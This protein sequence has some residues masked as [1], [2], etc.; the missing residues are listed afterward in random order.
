[1]PY[2][3]KTDKDRKLWI[4]PQEARAHVC[5]VERCKPTEAQD[6]ILLALADQNIRTRWGDAVP[7][8]Y[9]KSG[10]AKFGGDSPRWGSEP[11]YWHD[12]IINWDEG[13]TY[14][15]NIENDNFSRQSEAKRAGK[16]SPKLLD[17]LRPLLFL[18]RHVMKLWPTHN[19]IDHKN[20]SIQETF[21]EVRT[22]GSKLRKPR[23]NDTQ[24][25][26]L[27]RNKIELVVAAGQ[28]I[29]R[30]NRMDLRPLSDEIQRLGKNQEFS[31]E[32][33][34]KILAGRYPAQK[35][36]GIAGVK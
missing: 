29:T 7:V 21:V 13:T 32:T 9:Y 4:T 26:A 36:L 1:V 20:F 6:H 2:E 3:S 25:E 31:T 12:T 17:E 34:R 33:V 35:R 30:K 14:D 19:E 11:Y 24:K 18:K 8:G 23:K 15:P 16:K 10:L 22:I 5:E 28:A 27:L